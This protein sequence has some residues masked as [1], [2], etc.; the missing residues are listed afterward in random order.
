AANPKRPPAYATPTPPVVELLPFPS[1][2]GSLGNMD[3]ERQQPKLL[4][5]VRMS[6][7]SRHYSKRT[8]EAYLLWIRKFI[9]FHTKRHP[10]PMGA[11]EVNAFL[12]H[13][14]VDD[15]VAAATQNQALAALL[16]LYRIVLDDPLPWLHELIRAQRPVRLPIVLTLDEVRSV[17]SRLEGPSH[18]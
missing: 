15:N 3:T 4:D 7:R 11:D 16:F 18:I 10:A 8:E 17:L 6:L 9:L 5:R 14:A 1:H 13:L 2:R 12:S